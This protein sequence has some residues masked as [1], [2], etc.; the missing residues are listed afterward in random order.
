MCEF[1]EQPFWHEET[2]VRA[3][4]GHTCDFATE[5]QPE[6][7][8]S[9][10]TYQYGERYVDEHLCLEYANGFADQLGGGLMEMLQE[11]GNSEGQSLK[12][13]VGGSEACAR[14][15]N[16][17][18]LANLTLTTTFFCSRHRGWRE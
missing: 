5:A 10:A 12:P 4:D 1:C 7:C 11:T 13:I 17:A 8:G 14:C 16:P 9:R 3:K 2:Q 18:T 15:G 6:R